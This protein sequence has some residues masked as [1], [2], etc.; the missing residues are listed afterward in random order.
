VRSALLA[1]AVN[2]SD[3]AAGPT[4]VESAGLGQHLSLWA[5]DLS[6]SAVDASIIS[7]IAAATEFPIKVCTYNA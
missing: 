4:E 1:E 7:I 6:S 3:S 2:S 5:I